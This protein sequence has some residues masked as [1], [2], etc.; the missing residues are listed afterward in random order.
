[1][2]KYIKEV[3]NK[4]LQNYSTTCAQTP[5]PKEINRMRQVVVMKLN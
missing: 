1:M 2:N 3:K 4:I 5:G